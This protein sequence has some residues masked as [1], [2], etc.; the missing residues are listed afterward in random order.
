M[1]L[2]ATNEVTWNVTVEMAFL[3][4][5]QRAGLTCSVPPLT[6]TLPPLTRSASPPGAYQVSMRNLHNFGTSMNSV[7][8]LG[9]PKPLLKKTW[10]SRPLLRTPIGYAVD[11]QANPRSRN[12]SSPWQYPLDCSPGR[13]V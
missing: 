5:L 2:G 13:P 1:A 8:G 12:G 4:H 3:S 6:R 9:T 11:A 10:G 7:S